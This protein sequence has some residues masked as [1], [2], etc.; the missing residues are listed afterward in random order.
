MIILSHINISTVRYKFHI[1]GA[2]SSDIS[3][4]YFIKPYRDPVH[5]VTGSR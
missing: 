4:I 5:L 1:V 3:P 2:S